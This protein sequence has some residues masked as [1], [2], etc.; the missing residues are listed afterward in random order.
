[1]DDFPNPARRRLMLGAMSAGAGALLP[2]ELARAQE[3]DKNSLSIAYPVDVPTWDPNAVSIPTIQAIYQTVF[4]SPLRYSPHLKLEPRQVTQWKWQDDKATRLEITLRDDILFHDG[5]KMTMED[6]RYSLSERAK[7]DKKLLVGGMLNTLADIEIQSPTKGV[8]VFNRSTP[9]API[10]LGFLAVYVVPKAYMTKVGPEEFNARPIGAGPYR[11]V[12]HERGSRI[13]LEAFDKYWGGVA[14]IRHVTFLIVPEPAA[15]VALVE[16][17]RAGVAVQLPMREI[18]RLSTKPGLTTK[19]YP[20]SEVYM[21]R[22]PSYVKPFDDDHVRAAMHLSIDTAA[23]SKAFYGGVAKPLS[24][25]TPEGTP[26]FVD[27]KFPF[28]KAKAIEELKAAGY[29]PGNPVSLTLLST[30][31]TFPN[32]YDM[33]RAIAQM[34]KA[35][36]INATIEETT[37]AKLVEAAQNGKLTGA[38]LYSWANS[39]GDPENY[40]GRIF[41]PRLRFATWKDMSLAPLIDNLMTE[42]DESKRMAGYKALNVLSSQKSWAI[43]LLQGVTTVAYASALQPVLFDSGYVLPVEYKYK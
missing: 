37:P 28:D 23:L 9:A 16:S 7:A 4:D 30:N 29:S 25:M 24:V 6:V 35:V 32:D 11:M 8:M 36:G 20:F 41:D 18:Q 43:P 14:P 34:W 13:V 12:S 22:I 40:A 42:V 5:S 39:T 17:S 10:Y 21:L 38:L 2:W 33:A 27:F 19:I 15:R 1:M 31:G 26:S 3:L